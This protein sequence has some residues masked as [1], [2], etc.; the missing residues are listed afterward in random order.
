MHGTMCGFE[1]VFGV[2]DATMTDLLRCVQELRGRLSPKEKAQ[3]LSDFTHDA[4]CSVLLMDDTGAIGLDLSFVEYVFLMEPL[5]DAAHEQQV[6]SR[7]HRMGATKAVHVEVLVMQVCSSFY[8][9]LAMHY[10]AC[11]QCRKCLIRSCCSHACAR[12]CC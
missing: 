8:A 9:S 5:V 6:I 11:F 4:A 7:A 10:P 1:N 2:V 3:A 12:H